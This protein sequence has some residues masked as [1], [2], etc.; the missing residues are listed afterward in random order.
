M[1]FIATGSE[2]PIALKAGEQL[3]ERGIHSRVVSMPSWE[4]FEQ[5]PQEYRDRVLPPEIKARLAIEAG[6]SKGWHRYVGDQGR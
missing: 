2:V 4:L 6:S 5:Q 1:I 3:K